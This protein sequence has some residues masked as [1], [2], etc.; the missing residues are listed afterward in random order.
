[1]T[2]IL[3]YDKSKFKGKKSYG[4]RG[5]CSVCKTNSASWQKKRGRSYVTM[6]N[7]CAPDHVSQEVKQ[8]P[9]L[10][11]MI[12]LQ[13]MTGNGDI[14][15]WTPQGVKMLPTFMKDG[16]YR[17]YTAAGLVPVTGFDTQPNGNIM[18][19]VTGVL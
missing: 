7:D 3:K 14:R 13:I 1:M 10:E 19:K 2:E 18:F 5:L 12:E 8:T 16:V 11:T 6:C 4:A 9:Q 15:V 17:V